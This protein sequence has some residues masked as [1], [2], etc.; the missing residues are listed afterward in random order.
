ML[1]PNH[2]PTITESESILTGTFVFAIVYAMSGRPLAERVAEILCN[3]EDRLRSLMAE[4]ARAGDY[5]AV[6][7]IAAIAAQIR[8]LAVALD[9]HTACKG[10]LLAAHRSR[11]PQS[12]L[13][14]PNSQRSRR[15]GDQYPKFLRE[16]QDL[17]KVG[18]SKRKKREYRHKASRQLVF[19]LAET[20]KAQASNGRL[21][22]SAEFLPLRDPEDGQELP[23]CQAYVALA[24]LVQA[25]LVEKRGRQGYTVPD[26]ESFDRRLAEV[27]EAL[28]EP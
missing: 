10:G 23:D 15:T 5:D 9:E 17:V 3:S 8:G 1:R 20:L 14:K 7:R 26:P 18:W 11:V 24:W 2:Y 22:T 25:G 12:S 19:L 21:I 13:A 27:W 4:A 6:V 28:Q 16:R